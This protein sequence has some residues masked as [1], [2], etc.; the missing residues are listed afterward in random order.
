MPTLNW[1]GKDAVEHH[2]AEVPYRLVHCD[3]DLSAGDPDAGNLL[4][5]GDNLEALKALMPYY[6]G[7]VKCI[8]IDPPYNTGNEGWVYNDNL[9]DPEIKK[10]LGHVVGSEVEDLSRHDKWLCMMYPRLRLLKKF[11]RD[12]GVIFISIDDNEID[13]LLLLL[14]MIFQ[15]RNRIGVF[16]WRR[17]LTSDSRN[18]NNVSADHEYLVCYG[19]SHA[20]RFK[21]QDRDEEKYKNPDKDPRGAWMSDNLTGLADAKSRPN[22]HYVVKNPETNATYP[23]HPQRGWAVAPDTM[24]RLIEEGRI[25]WPKSATGRPRIKRYLAEL[26]ERRAGYST[27][28][29]APTNQAGT[30]TLN[31]IFGEKVFDFPKPHEYVME[32]IS[33][34]AVN[35][36]DLVLDSFAGSGTTGQAVLSLN[37]QDGVSRR[38]ILIEMNRNTSEQVTA[39]RLNRVI[40]GYDKGGDSSKP[41][42]GLGGGFRY[43]RLGV[44]LFNE[45]GDIDTA[46][47]FPDLAA[48][49]FFAETGVPIPS[50]ATGN[51]PYLGKHG[52]KAVY[53]LFAPG[54]EGMPREAMGNVLTP[55]ALA[56]LPAPPEGFEGS[57]V[58]YAEGCTVS[59]DRLKSEGVVFKQ[60]PY[61]VEGV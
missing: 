3:G 2:H 25:L 44:P 4:V 48:H 23:P 53:L 55:D 14:D 11:L 30:R 10:W 1:I 58:V 36:G 13:H 33:Q 49:I 21:G 41:I 26:G 35:D 5:Q 40:D 18:T 54:Q 27:I 37:K 9:N 31:D 50:K 52:S 16:V 56:N 45:F 59:P 47:S 38:F 22:L 6:G 32:V 46:V 24:E 42:E 29:N 19:G 20:A 57:R 61:Q 60:I 8:Y 28:V 39:V 17:R 12:D 15:R 51:S 34:I 43:C 7:Q